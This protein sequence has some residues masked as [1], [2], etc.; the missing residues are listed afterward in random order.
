MLLPHIVTGLGLC[1]ADD[2]EP[3]QNPSLTELVT[4]SAAL[5]NL[6]GTLGRRL[7]APV[8]ELLLDAA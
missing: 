5:V 4:I 6:E 8:P 2:G 1:E 7:R 3:A